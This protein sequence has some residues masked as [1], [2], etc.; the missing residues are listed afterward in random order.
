MVYFSLLTSDCYSTRQSA[1]SH[2]F[3]AMTFGNNERIP[4]TVSN[5]YGTKMALSLN[6]RN[7]AMLH[8]GRSRGCMTKHG[9][10][11]HTHVAKHRL[12]ASPRLLRTSPCTFLSVHHRW[13]HD[14]SF[15]HHRCTHVLDCTHSLY[16]EGTPPSTSSPSSCTSL[17][18]THHVPPPPIAGVA[19]PS[20]RRTPS[21]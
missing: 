15:F 19:L 9:V 16:K 8:Y 18:S 1:T 5:P 14:F 6:D 10:T 21:P 13:I 11:R 2:L 17:R 4:L 7:L 3:A 20:T 12:T